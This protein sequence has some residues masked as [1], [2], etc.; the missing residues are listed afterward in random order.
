M[1]LVR[2]GLR[3]GSLL[4]ESAARGTRVLTLWGTA[5][6]PESAALPGEAPGARLWL[7]GLEATQKLGRRALLYTDDAPGLL[8]NMSVPS[9][10]THVTFCGLVPGAH[11]RVDIASSMGDVTQSITGYTSESFGSGLEALVMGRDVGVKEVLSGAGQRLSQGYDMAPCQ[12]ALFSGPLPPQTLEVISRSSPSDLT[13]GWAPGPG[14]LEGYKI[15]WHQDGSQRSP[16]GL[17]DLGPDKSSLTL[18]SLVPGSCYTVSAWAWAGNLSSNSR[19]IHSC[20]REFLPCPLEAAQ[21]TACGPVSSAVS[22][23]PWCQGK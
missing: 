17:V 22:S 9:G 14:Q 19:K 23:S 20:T 5:S 6:P 8:E 7:D 4:R 11:Y 16:G 2:V 18:K 10:A 13:I 12:I 15:T 1:S 21:R 3:L